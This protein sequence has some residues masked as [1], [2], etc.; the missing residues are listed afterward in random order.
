MTLYILFLRYGRIR[1]GAPS[2]ASHLDGVPRAAEGRS[3]AEIEIGDL[4]N[5][6]FVKECRREYIE[7]LRHLRAPG[8]H[9]LRSEQATGTDVSGHTGVK[10]S[11]PRIVGLVVI[12]RAHC[13][14]RIE[15]FSLR[16][17]VPEAGTRKDE[18]EDLDHLRS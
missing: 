5:R 18:V 12:H 4:V 11:C 1:F 3:V 2:L 9:D 14:K 16:F 6:H 8:P 17:V 7:T 13:R 10:L 15:G